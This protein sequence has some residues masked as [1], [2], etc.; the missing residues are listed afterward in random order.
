[1]VHLCNAHSVIETLE[2]ISADREEGSK[3]EWRSKRGREEGKRRGRKEIRQ[4]KKIK[5]DGQE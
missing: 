5:E 1:L 4:E 2:G 3:D